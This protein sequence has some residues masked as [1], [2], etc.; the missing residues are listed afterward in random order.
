MKNSLH[1]F[2]W[3]SEMKSKWQS[4]IIATNMEAKIDHFLSM[5]DKNGD[6]TLSRDEVLQQ[7][8][9]GRKMGTVRLYFL[10]KETILELLV[11]MQIIEFVKHMKVVCKIDVDNFKGELPL[12]TH[13]V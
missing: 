9:N 10:Y 12:D 11:V 13:R 3:L 8:L 2:V 4:F 6:G 7:Y 5:V 1:E